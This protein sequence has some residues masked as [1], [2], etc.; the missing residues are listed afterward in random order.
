MFDNF[1]DYYQFILSKYNPLFAAEIKVLLNAALDNYNDGNWIAYIADLRTI[2]LYLER[3][4]MKAEA[5]TTMN[6]IVLLQHGLH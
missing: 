1:Y 6:W 3:T 2:A 4:G 5:R